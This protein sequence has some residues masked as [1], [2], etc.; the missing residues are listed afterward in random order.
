MEHLQF[1]GRVVAWEQAGSGPAVLFVHAFPLSSEMWEPQ[2]RTIP[3]VA[4][5]LRFDAPG[6]GAS[7]PVT[8]Y[9]LDDV[10]RSAVAVLDAAGVERAVVCGLSMGGYIALAM[11]RLFPERLSGL[12][13]GDTR[14]EPDTEEAKER[15]KETARRVEAEGVAFLSESLPTALL[16]P[17]VAENVQNWLLERLDVTAPQGVADALR[18]MAVRS[19]SI[20]ILPAIE[21]PTLVICGSEDGLT[22]PESSRAMAQLIPDAR[23]EEI[24][25]VGHLSS[26]EAPQAFNDRLK[27]F[28]AS[29]SG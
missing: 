25:G 12:V 20:P 14:A 2:W 23:Y 9:T 4:H 1:E 22:P 21:V 11:A 15:R 26:R 13:L 27:A 24:E 17:D 18:A 19:D 3:D 29:F 10:A 8:G 7:D 28:L 6:F 16:G 5:C